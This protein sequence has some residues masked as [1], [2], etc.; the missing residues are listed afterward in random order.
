M[1]ATL[2]LLIFF[3]V[4][5]SFAQRNVYTF[6]DGIIYTEEKVRAYI[7]TAQRNSSVAYQ[8]TPIIYHKVFSKD[9]I[10]NYLTISMVNLDGQPRQTVKFQYLQDSVFLLLNK[11][12]PKF[13]LSDLNGTLVSSES[14]QGKPMLINFWN[15][16]CRPCIDEMP[17]LS[18]LKDKYGDEMNFI[19]VTD[20][21]IEEMDLIAFLKNKGFNFPVLENGGDYA[22]LINISS[23]P[24]NIFIDRNGVV[25]YIQRNYPLDLQGKEVPMDSPDNFFTKIVAELLDTSR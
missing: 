9:T 25:R 4:S 10:V 24:R 16:R 1:K 21:R 14:L 13:N 23:L 2:L 17:Q 12:L 19:S 11:K 7:D 18:K 22:K 20:D 8:V 15:T 3:S 5:A 6:N